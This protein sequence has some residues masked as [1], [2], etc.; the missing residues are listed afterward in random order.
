MEGAGEARIC[1]R[2]D[3]VAGR[4]VAAGRDTVP[5]EGKFVSER[6]VADVLRAE[7][8]G[9]CG[10]FPRF[11]RSRLASVVCGGTGPDAAGTGVAISARAPATHHRRRRRVDRRQEV[12][13]EPTGARPE[14][15]V[16]QVGV[17]SGSR[18]PGAVGASDGVLD[19][20]G[21]ELFIYREVQTD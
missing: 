17:A 3:E 21:D 18:R 16:R 13:R 8:P 19:G 6:Q 5:G 10:G 9:V 4:A 2:V 20:V 7:T 14:P 11:L 1:G 12:H 15:A